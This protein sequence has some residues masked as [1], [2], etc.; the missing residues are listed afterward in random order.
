MKARSDFG[1]LLLRLGPTRWRIVFGLVCVTLSG[2]AATID[3]LLMRTLI[4]SALPQQS[5]RWAFE[6]AAGIGL[7]YFARSALGALGSLVNFSIAQRCVR[8]LRVALLDQI[9]RLSADYHEQTPTGEKLTRMEHDVDEIA[10]LGADTASQ[11]VRAILFFALNL[12]MMARMNLPMTLTVLPL[13]P[14]FAIVQRRFSALLKVRADEARAEVGVATSMLT[15]HLAAVPQIQLLGAEEASALRTVSACDA[16]LRTQ[17]IQRQTQIGFSLSMGA[18]L[19]AAILAVLCFGSEK[20]LAGALTIGGL[21]AF[22][23][24]GTRVF[25]PVSSAMELYSRLQSVGASIRR[26]RELLD[27]E[28]SVKD[29]GTEC[30]EPASL[31]NGFNIQDVSFSY[32][33]DATLSNLTLQI[34]AGER[35]AIIGPSGSGKSTLARL[36]VRAADPGSGRILLENRPLADYTLAS[37]RKTVCFVPQHPVLFQGSIRENLLYGN[38]RATTE[39][40]LNAMQAVELISVLNRL[41]LGLDTPL[42]PGAVGF[43]GGECQRLALA[44]SL[45]RESAALILDEATS[46]LDGPTERAVLASLSRFRAHQTL[47]VISHRISSLTWVDRFVLIDQGRIAAVG[48]HSLLYVQS[49]LYRALYDSSDQDLTVP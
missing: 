10:N 48:P 6:L 46:A 28:P 41:P 32:G 43:S 34:G 42:G 7:C 19:A 44:R 1:W 3:P 23:A 45:L 33:R 21:V 17:W 35:V 22:Y 29:V 20:V 40:M 24:Y 27:L 16:M 5:M 47:I 18:I 37:V 39:E 25:D 30:L 4:D 36:L 13:M 14:L 38:P 11:S 2:L 15:E 12:A 8:D 9:N 31:T 26:V 49:Q